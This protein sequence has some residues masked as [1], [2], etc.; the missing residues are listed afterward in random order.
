MKD[1]GETKQI[2]GIEVHIDDNNG[3]LWLQ[4]IMNMVE[5]INIPISFHYKFSSSIKSCL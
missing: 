3:K 1:Q 2:V 5:P 4:F